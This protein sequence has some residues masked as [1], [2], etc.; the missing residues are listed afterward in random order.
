MGPLG[1][2]GPVGPPGRPTGPGLIAPPTP[3]FMPPQVGDFIQSPRGYRYRLVASISSGGFSTVYDAVDI[4]ETHL[5][6]KV[7]APTAPYPEV[8]ERW[9]AEAALLQQLHHPNIT[10]IYDA[11]EY[12]S[13]FYL[14]LEKATGNLS[15][16]I[17]G[18]P[19]LHPNAVIYIAQQ[20]LM[21]LHFIHERQ[22]IHEDLHAG[23][24][25]EYPGGVVKISDFGISRRLAVAH[26]SVA[27]QTFHRKFVVPELASQGYTTQQS[28]LY[29]LGLILYALVR[30]LHAIDPNLPDAEISRQAVEGVPRA[31][32]EALGTPIGKAIAK[33]LRRRGQYRYGSA[34]DAWNDI[35]MLLPARQF[36]GTPGGMIPP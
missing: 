7:F 26:G 34:L 22:V 2:P 27:P 13:G 30:G 19:Q 4:F 11:F 10:Y 33:L 20:L 6:V 1:P 23:N 32:A 15:R 28:D 31:R 24:I 9:F 5:A 35:R 21:A 36:D 18:A 25:L 17:T 16:Y 12:R 29:H 14:V 8:R 3:V